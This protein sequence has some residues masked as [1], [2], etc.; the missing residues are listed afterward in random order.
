MREL[1]EK[2]KESRRIFDI[3]RIKA[4]I[5]EIDIRYVFIGAGTTL[6]CGAISAILSG[7]FTIYDFWVLPK[8]APPRFVFPIVW[9]ILYI[10]IGGCA[11]AVL[12]NCEKYK[13]AD[14]YKGILLFTIMLIF[15]LVWSPLF[16]GAGSFFIAYL[17]LIIT[18][19]LTVFVICYFTNIYIITALPMFFYFVWLLFAGYLNFTIIILN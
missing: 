2:L 12:S 19:L 5:R 10:L 7:G 16:F 18:A 6:F 4:E 8:F 15:N 9:T 3:S 13:E 14:K 1:M 11:G 17:D